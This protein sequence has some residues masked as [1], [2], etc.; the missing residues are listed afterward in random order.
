MNQY[1]THI[2]LVTNYAIS[3]QTCVLPGGVLP[4]GNKAD[5]LDFGWSISGEWGVR[6][7]VEAESEADAI[8]RLRTKVSSLPREATQP[9]PVSTVPVRLRDPHEPAWPL[10]ILDKR[11]TPQQ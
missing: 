1:A 2:S 8:E 11:P 7:V 6:S 3:Y 4:N 10:W 9:K 5:L